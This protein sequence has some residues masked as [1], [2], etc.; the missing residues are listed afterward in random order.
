MKVLTVGH[1]FNFDKLMHGFASQ[2]PMK[3][4]PAHLLADH[5]NHF[6][7]QRKRDGQRHYALI[8]DKRQVRLYSS[9][10]RDMTAHFPLIVHELSEMGLPAR[11]VLD[12]EIIC[13]R[14]GVDDFRATNEC[15]RAHAPTSQTAERRL[16]IRYMPFDC[17]FYNG[18][19]LWQL[20]YVDRWD[21]LTAMIGEGARIVLPETFTRLDIAQ[22]KVRDREWEGLV[23]WQPSAEALIR[24]DGSSARHGSYKWKPIQERDFV[25]VGWDEGKGK[26]KGRMGA[27]LLAE[28]SEGLGSNQR[29]GRVTPGWVTIGNVGTG[30]TDRERS[31]AMKWKYPCVVTVQ[32]MFQ[33]PDTRALREP[34]FI[35]RETIKKVSD[36]R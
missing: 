11:T 3:E 34:R 19:R 26:H 24:L 4:A 20:P 12:G 5:R 16:P 27:L 14:H 6:I 36:L 10:I 15:C 35:R 29:L 32:F 25:C 31:D 7:I 33:Q 2:K 21:Q 13:D 1:I 23:L 18:S 9:T 30:F 8:T 22:R 17:L 28:W